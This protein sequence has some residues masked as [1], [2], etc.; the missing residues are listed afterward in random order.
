MNGKRHSASPYYEASRP[1]MLSR[2]RDMSLGD[3][4]TSSKRSGRLRQAERDEERAGEPGAQARHQRR[5][6]T[7]VLSTST[8]STGASSAGRR[9]PGPS[10]ARPGRSSRAPPSGSRDGRGPARSLTRLG[11]DRSPGSIR[12]PVRAASTRVSDAAAAGSARARSA[13][14]AP[15]RSPGPADLARGPS[16]GRASVAMPPAPRRRSR[17]R[18]SRR[19]GRSRSDARRRVAGPRHM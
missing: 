2:R 12:R 17:R 3:S 13:A 16:A 18:D 19:R 5:P 8:T 11:G 15:R 14:S 10:A 6:P 9:P 1:M 7:L 4:T